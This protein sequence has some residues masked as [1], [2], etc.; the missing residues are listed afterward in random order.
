MLSECLV[1]TFA[2]HSNSIKWCSQFAASWA[3]PAKLRLV[4]WHRLCGYLVFSFIDLALGLA[5]GS[6]LW[7]H[8]EQL[9]DVSVARLDVLQRKCLVDMLEWFTHAPGGVQLNALLTRHFNEAVLRFL[10]ALHLLHQLIAPY[11]VPTLRLVACLGSL[12]LTLQL[13][14]LVDLF[15]LVTL[16]LTV[17]FLVV[18]KLETLL[19]STLASLW[20]LFNGRK[21]NVLRNSRID[22]YRYDRTQLLLGTALF[23]I[24]VFVSPTFTALF[25]LLLSLRLVLV[26]VEVVFWSAIVFVRHLPVYKLLCLLVSYTSLQ[27]NGI[28][29]VF[30]SSAAA[31]HPALAVPHEAHRAPSSHMS[32]DSL[33]QASSSIYVRPLRAHAAA[34]TVGNFRRK[35]GR[36]VH[37]PALPDS[38]ENESGSSTPLRRQLSASVDDGFTSEY[39]A[40]IEG[41]PLDAFRVSGRMQTTPRNNVMSV[42][43]TTHMQLVAVTRS[44]GDI[45]NLKR[46]WAL[47][48]D[49]DKISRAVL[50]VCSGRLL[51]S[52][53]HIRHTFPRLE[54]GSTD[55]EV[56]FSDADA[57]PEGELGFWADVYA[58]FGKAALSHVPS[59]VL[60]QYRL[61]RFILVSVALWHIVCLGSVSLGAYVFLSEYYPSL[62]S[63]SWYTSMWI[64]ETIVLETEVETTGT[65]RKLLLAT[66]LQV[67]S[68]F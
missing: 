53:D 16:H 49:V 68:A 56:V 40:V 47:L 34:F 50:L 63:S 19:L 4:L 27:T 5:L 41:E 58:S 31:A 59:F 26:A 64:G 13:A 42:K 65:A 38:S 29:F 55:E 57:S 39:N 52:L 37:S 15:R 35:W 23:A 24:L 36:G 67:Y 7:H 1:D 14:C 17:I 66:L 11:Q 6:L 25:L 51:L 21:V 33:P 61:N 28:K 48:T 2:T 32:L 8:A 44:P 9:V 12:G 20:Y 43:H 3:R 54:I 60:K 46:L 10:H 62:V 45:C 22:S 18:R 30:E